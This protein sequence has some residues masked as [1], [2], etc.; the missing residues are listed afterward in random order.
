MIDQILDTLSIP[1]NAQTAYITLLKEG[2]MTA[3][4]LAEK[5]GMPRATVYDALNILMSAGLVISREEEGKAI[6]SVADPNTL[7]ILLDQRIGELQASKKEVTTILDTLRKQSQTIE[8]K[9]RFFSNKE[10]V[11]KIL[12][13]IGWYSNIETYTLWPMNEMLELLGPQYLERLNKRRVEQKISLRSIRTYG[14]KVNLNTYPF[15][16]NRP[17]NLRELR[18]APKKFS[19]DM[20]YWI[21]ADKVAFI[22]AYG[23]IFGF[24]VHSK[25]FS[26]MLKLHF[27]LL[28]TMSKEK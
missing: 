22:S 18:Y 4:T 2:S 15:L 12:N 13:D 17:E 26:S 14:S 19:F 11:Q 21:Y 1:K 20:S 8:P 16:G 7:D 3:R 25:E 10:G 24:I 23:G 5:I 27:D 6:Y 28:W 9:I